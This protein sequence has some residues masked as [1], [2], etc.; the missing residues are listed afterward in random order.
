MRNAIRASWRWRVLLG[1]ALLPAVFGSGC[2]SMSN[3]ETGAL[4]GGGIGAAAGALAAGPRH[5]GIGALVGAGIG[6]AAG[7]LTGKAVDNSEKKAAAREAAL[8]AISLEDIARLTASGTSD[9]VI[10]NQIR[11][12]GTIYSLTAEQLIWL[13]NNGVREPVIREMQATATR[14]RRVY[15]AVPVQPVYV[16]DPYPP[17]PPVGVGVGVTYVGGRHW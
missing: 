13:Q 17:P 9:E 4:A 6:A 14:P 11:A 1:G 8:R 5:A 7:A 3:T 2:Q 15:T 10:I 12:S 16:V